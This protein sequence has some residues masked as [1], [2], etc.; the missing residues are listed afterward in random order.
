[1]TKL[2]LLT[3]LASLSLSPAAFALDGSLSFD[4]KGDLAAFAASRE[5]PAPVPGAAAP[6]AETP[7][8]CVFNGTGGAALDGAAFK[9][10][11]RASDVVYVGESHDQANDH[12]A[13]LEA[14]KALHEARGGS[15]VVGFEML[16]LTLQPVLD[17]YAS[18]KLTEAE[19]LRQ[20][21]W[22]KEWGFDFNLYKPIFDFI[23]EKK[24]TA[25][26]LNLPK[27]IVSKIAR[28]GLA[29]LTPA[30]QAYLPANLQVTTNERYIA[31]IRES[32]DGQMSDMFKFENYLA[33]MSAWN[34]TMGA[35]LADFLNANPGFA[36]LTVAGSGHIIYNAGIPASLKARTP[37]ARGLSFFMQGADA[38]PA[39]LPEA[40]SGLAD[41]VWY[42]RHT[43]RA[44]RA[45][46]VPLILP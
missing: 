37:G 21:D 10:A 34:E 30:E 41:Y 43:G 45:K 13:Q 38:C 33:A 15:V 26:A 39:A 4:Q 27:K 5:I 44:G 35:R 29:G 42:V 46:T 40:D 36:G 19:F 17:G 14:L 20:A 22:Q 32:F 1:M 23:R 2:P 8:L 28:A 3:L 24:L 7:G 6:A 9:A 16:N 18:G 31:Y 12:L 25:L 11:I